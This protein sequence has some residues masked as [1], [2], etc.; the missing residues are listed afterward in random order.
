MFFMVQR[1]SAW[2]KEQLWNAERAKAR[3]VTD[4]KGKHI[5]KGIIEIVIAMWMHGFTTRGSCQGHINRGAPFLWVDFLTVTPK[6]LKNP[7]VQKAWT[8]ENM[9][10]RKKMFTLLAEF[11]RHRRGPFDVRLC[12]E[13]RSIFGGFRLQ[14]QGALL[15]PALTPKERTRKLFLYRNELG[16]FRY[17]LRRKYFAK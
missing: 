7:S 4:R 2:R 8:E 10:L 5:E 16:A 6:D 1:L 11:Y 9:A 14:S 17:F 3:R 15:I 13:P 12:L